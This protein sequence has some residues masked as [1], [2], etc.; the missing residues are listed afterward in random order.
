M[1]LKL[2]YFGKVFSEI[3]FAEADDYKALWDFE[4]NF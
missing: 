2:N 4:D 1:K 3:A